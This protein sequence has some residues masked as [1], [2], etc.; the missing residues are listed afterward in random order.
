MSKW[1]SNLIE[2]E[3]NKK[4]LGCPYCA[5]HNIK[6]LE[7]EGKRKSVTFICENCGK[8]EHFDKTVS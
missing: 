6:V 1:I 5:S 3:K 2:Y 7:H 8:S 4:V